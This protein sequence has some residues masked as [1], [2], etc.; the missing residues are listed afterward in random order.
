MQNFAFVI[1]LEQYQSYSCF[2][3]AMGGGGSDFFPQFSK[4]PQFRKFL[5]EMNGCSF[6]LDFPDFFPKNKEFL[7]VM[8]KMPQISQIPLISCA[9]ICGCSFEFLGR[10]DF[11]DFFPKFRKLLWAIIP[12]QCVEFLRFLKCPAHKIFL[13]VFFFFGIS[14]AQI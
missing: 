2:F 7:W 6:E 9:G 11:L 5:R 13:Y 8:L 4:F 1:Y 14:L 12:R 3:F 10:G